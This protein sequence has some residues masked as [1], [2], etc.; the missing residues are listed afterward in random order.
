MLAEVAGTRMVN[1]RE[2]S[3]CDI[4][5]LWE[6]PASIYG[7]VH[8]GYSESLNDSSLSAPL[9]VTLQSRLVLRARTVVG[10]GAGGKNVD[11]D[12]TTAG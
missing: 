1:E 2:R 11:Y 7:L 5:V 3:G 12:H 9:D 6:G 8:D 10:N 4:A